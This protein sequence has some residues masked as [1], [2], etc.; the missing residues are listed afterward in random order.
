MSCDDENDTSG[1]C[2]L[3]EMILNQDLKRPTLM[4]IPK[5][6]EKNQEY[7]R[8]R[9]S[10]LLLSFSY[11][12]KPESIKRIL[13]NPMEYKNYDNRSLCDT[14]YESLHFKR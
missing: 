7:L 14:S 4:K 2:L 1:T 5:S 3:N 13:R 8:K 9:V 11:S 12:R 6:A 10:L